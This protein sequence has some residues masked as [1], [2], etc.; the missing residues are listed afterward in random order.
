MKRVG[1]QRIDYALHR[2]GL[3]IERLLENEANE[4]KARAVRWMAAWK[5]MHEGGV[6]D[7]LNN[8]LPIG[9]ASR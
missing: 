9:V 3:A 2:I 4:E 1:Q 5:A 7:G 8:S 6:R